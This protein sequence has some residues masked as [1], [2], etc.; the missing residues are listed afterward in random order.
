MQFLIDHGIDMTIKD[1][2]WNSTALGWAEYGAEDAKLAHWLE[3]AGRQRKL[4]RKST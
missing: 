2:R 4:T 3:E 1:Y